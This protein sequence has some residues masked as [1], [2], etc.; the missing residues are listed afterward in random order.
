MWR[1]GTMQPR[2][3]AALGKALRRI[4]N[5][6]PPGDALGVPVMG[7]PHKLDVPVMDSLSLH[8]GGGQLRFEE[9]GVIHC[10]S[11]AAALEVALTG[12]VLQAR[13]ILG[14]AAC[15]IEQGKALPPAWCAFIGGALHAV[16]CRQDARR[17]FLQVHRRG[18][19]GNEWRDAP[20]VRLHRVLR[21]FGFDT[22]AAGEMVFRAAQQFGV[23][24]EG[25]LKGR[26]VKVT[27]KRISQIAR[28][29]KVT[30]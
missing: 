18:R 19:P 20:F 26:E 7:R 4:A 27:R 24:V 9:D 10:V 3:R 25:R 22:E 12:N 1:T 29:R 16:A 5:G 6:V 8:E 21:E 30:D 2:E 11:A 23:D 13:W 14:I 15:C 28:G 17:A